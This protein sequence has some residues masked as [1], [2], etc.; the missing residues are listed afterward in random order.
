[1]LE[2]V[3][4][5]ELPRLLVAGADPE[6]QVQGDLI[7][8]MVLFEHDDQAVVEHVGGR[9]GDHRVGPRERGGHEGG[10]EREG[11]GHRGEARSV[12]RAVTRWLGSPT[13]PEIVRRTG[14]TRRYRPDRDTGRKPQ[15]YGAD[16]E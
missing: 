8:P 2:Q 12:N 9:V 13:D 16:A 10:R 6:P 5:A 14:A 15:A 1:V 11:H 3:S 4:A 7:G